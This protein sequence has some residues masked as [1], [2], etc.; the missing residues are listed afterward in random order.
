M[1]KPRIDRTGSRYGHLTVLKYLGVIPGKVK[2]HWLCMCDCG[3][4]VCV[5]TSNLTT[6]HTLSCGCAHRRMLQQ[7][8]VYPLDLQGEYRIWRG[9]KQRTSSTRGKRNS[10]YADVPLCERW[11]ASFTAFIADMGKR[12]NNTYSIERLDNTKGYFPDNCVWASAKQQANNRCTNV[13]LTYLGSTKT[14]AQWA[15]QLLIA[16]G[17]LRARIYVYGWSVEKALTTPVKRR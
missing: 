14:I 17:T 12:P 8:R 2:P 13:H 6:G 1:P 9:M 3:E 4:Q 15:D 11:A 5:T 10:R 7:R 16:A